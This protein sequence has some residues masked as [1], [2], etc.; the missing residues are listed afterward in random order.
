MAPGGGGGCGLV[1]KHSIYLQFYFI[2]IYFQ[3]LRI[4]AAYLAFF[5]KRTVSAGGASIHG[6]FTATGLPGRGLGP[7]KKKKK[8]GF[9]KYNP[10]LLK[11]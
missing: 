11:N 3:K 2:Y 9:A 4:L 8:V 5:L 7:L 1:L 6:L 10:L